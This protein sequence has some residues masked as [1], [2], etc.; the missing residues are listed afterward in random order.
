[1]RAHWLRKCRFAIFNFALILRAFQRACDVGERTI[2]PSD[3]GA[4]RQGILLVRPKVR[5]SS[6]HEIERRCF[7]VKRTFLPL[8]GLSL[9]IAVMSSCGSNSLKSITITAP[10]NELQGEGGTLQLTATGNYSYGPTNNLTDKVT[11]TI[12]VDGTDWTGATLPTP[13]QGIQLSSTGMLTA[14]DP[15]ACSFLAQGS[16]T[17]VT[18]WALTG[19]YKVVAAY[20]GVTSQPFYVGLASAAG[21][22]AQP[23]DGACG[24]SSSSN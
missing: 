21:D 22:P 5:L 15:F 18:G 16:G 11:F 17:T 7:N 12:T 4:L 3:F 8:I 19:S 13:P 23:G 9:L 10:S 1:M 6:S 14:V 24:P 2:Q 20:D